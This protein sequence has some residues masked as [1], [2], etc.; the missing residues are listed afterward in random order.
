MP[1]QI[2][3]G[4]TKAQKLAVETIDGPVLVI[5]GPGTGKT[6]LLAQR[7]ANI[8]LKTDVQPQNILCLTY[9]EAAARNMRD[10][11]GKYMGKHA[12]DVTISTYH[13]F[14]S[15][16]IRDHREYFLE[17]NAEQ[18]IDNL[19]QHQILEE[20][21]QTISSNNALWRK[22][23]YLKD[24]LQFI[25]E[26]K[27]AGLMPKDI[28]TIA[29]DNTRAINTLNKFTKKDLAGLTKMSKS[30]IPLFEKL[31]IETKSLPTPTKKLPINIVHLD[32]QFITAL[33]EAY[34][35][36]E[37]TGRTVPITAFKNEWLTKDKDDNW[38]VTGANEVAKLLGAADIYEQYL[39]KLKDNNLYDYDDMI[40]RA[41]EAI[42]KHSELRFSLQEKYQY[43]ML[44]EFQDTNKAQLKLIE[45]LTNNPVNEGRPNILAVGDDDQ[46]IFSFQGAEIDNMLRFYN[47]YKDVKTITLT[48][49]WRSHQDIINTAQHVSGQIEK[50]LHSKLGI[51][52]KDLLATN[53]TLPAQAKIEQHRFIS[54]VAE[55][56]WV[57]NKVE[58][59]INKGQSPEGIAVLAPKHKYLEPLVPFL[60]QKNIPLRYEKR[61]NVLEDQYIARLISMLRLIDAL[62]INDY[63]KSNELWPEILTGSEW[64][65]PTSQIWQLSWQSSENKYKQDATT[66]W[67]QLMLAEPNLKPI[68]LF[69]AKLA[70]IANTETL[71]KMLDYCI[72]IEP[73]ELNEP[74]ISSFSSPFYNYYFE[75]GEAKKQ[76]L[77]F[78][79]LLSHLTVLRQR[80]REHATQ[81]NDVLH[82]K[83]ALDFID[84][85]N[86]AN[87]KLLNTS[88]YHTAANAVQLITAY[89][90]KG[91]EFD[92][93]FVLA[94]ID[95]VWGMKARG[96]SS[97]ITLPK[98]L[99]TI[100]FAGAQKDEKKRLFYVALTRAKHTLYL[101]SFIKNYAGKPTTELEFMSQQKDY[102][103]LQQNMPK[104]VSNLHSN[105][106]SNPNA[107][108][109][110]LFWQTHHYNSLTQPDLKELL[111]PRLQ[112]FQLSATHL[113]SFTDME[114]GGPEQFFVN[115]ILRFPKA[116]SA[117][118]EYGSAI[119][120]SIEAIANMQKNTGELPV[121][122][123]IQEIFAKKLSKKT[124]NK[125]EYKQY[126]NRGEKA[127][128]AFMQWWWPNFDI[129]NQ[130]EVRFKHE[131]AFCG[132][133]HLTGNLDYLVIDHEDQ[134]IQVVD[135]KTSQSFASWAKSTK[136]HK[137]KQQLLFYKILLNSSHTYKNYNISNGRVVFV[138]PDQNDK[139][140]DLSLIYN[141][142]DLDRTKKLIQAIW[143]RVM[144]LDFPDTTGFS[145]NINGTLEFEDWLINNT[146]IN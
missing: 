114:L 12:Y 46:A 78:T 3:K 15:E 132:K 47:L 14:G 9:T 93:V 145:K 97:N 117:N 142:I 28:R 125:N 29:K 80:L 79:Q 32:T 11:M 1:Q 86:N 18:P 119:H 76:T 94:T 127:L 99:Q 73:L 42:S 129:Q 122:E 113:N 33:A 10:R 74:D 54:D 139:M 90:A 25:G 13:G 19:L 52:S 67:L 115:T 144:L 103:A 38:V 45:L 75:S 123:E 85:Y 27:R 140:T 48:E 59:I 23:T 106:A 88:P 134:D 146:D 37:A 100:R 17:H 128:A 71:E 22:E 68:A 63:L 110:Q 26:A 116:P 135:Y 108:T 16:I 104:I 81:K 124:L 109:L 61:E 105:D 138:E 121:L 55:L 84:S 44:D 62:S 49:N 36:T 89:S 34:V 60:E 141:D 111:K 7:A 41:T 69:F 126:L 72:G 118:G 102:S 101:T 77:I 136:S 50:R 92:V 65:I 51:S 30:S 21:Y 91:L 20:I 82:L 107:K 120:E 143:N 131:G 64:Q 56:D 137:Y 57:A 95:D 43:I 133:A 58:E 6:Q 39:K 31:F 40:L 2:F 5:A 53:K 98:N 96:A 66:N 35:E 130:A 4:L 8:L 24:V 70:S 83:D 112:D 87:E